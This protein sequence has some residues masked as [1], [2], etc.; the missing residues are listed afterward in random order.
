MK[1]SNISEANLVRFFRYLDFSK[2]LSIK[3]HIILSIEMIPF[4]NL[5]L[6]IVKYGLKYR[7]PKKFPR[8]ESRITFDWVIYFQTFKVFWTPQSMRFSLVP[9]LETF[10]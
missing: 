10:V 6:I 8:F 2:P 1:K 5:Y 4:V 7:V 9:V 3:I